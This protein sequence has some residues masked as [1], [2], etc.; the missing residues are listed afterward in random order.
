LP[1]LPGINLPS[2]GSAGYPLGLSRRVAILFQDV[3]G[4]KSTAIFRLAGCGQA[5]LDAAGRACKNPA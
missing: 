3:F 1:T 2:A 5:Q 4:G